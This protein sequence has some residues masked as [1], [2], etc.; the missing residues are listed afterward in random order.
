MC[1]LTLMAACAALLTLGLGV[2]PLYAQEANPVPG[3]PAESIAE[4]NPTDIDIASETK[5]EK[6]Q[7]VAVGDKVKDF[8]LSDID[9]NEHSLS[10][11]AGKI[12][13]LS[14]TNPECPYIVAHNKEKTLNKVAEKYAD[15]DVVVL[16]IDSSNDGTTERLKAM[17]EDHGVATPILEDYDSK[18][19]RYFDAKTTPHV[20]VID[21]EGELVY[22]GAIDNA[23]LG[24]LN[25]GEAEKINYAEAVVDDLLA[26]REVRFSTTKP[27]GCDVKY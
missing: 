15:E 6:K 24:R 26:G 17:R 21:K 16:Q 5:S 1:R 19:G 2:S 23:P 10:D 27:Y 18:T 8:T 11:F 14:W 4:A 13:V 20:Y 9:G 7:P 12:V 3:Q 22:S 25:E